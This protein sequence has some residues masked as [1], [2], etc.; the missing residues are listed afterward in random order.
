VQR[1]GLKLVASNRRARFDYEI[2]ETFEAGLVLTG[3]EV[4]SLRLG[5]ASLNESFAR[6]EG[7]EVFLE[8]MHVP[9]YEQGQT[10]GYDPRRTR[11]LL[12]H[13]GEIRRLI[14]KTSER[15]L[16]LVPMRLYFKRGLAKV[17][18]GLGR[19]KAKFEKR[20]AL[21]E[22]EHAREMQ[23]ALGSRRPRSG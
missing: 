16:T 22:K 15:G 23:R 11:K 10:R 2:E 6:I 19:G 20:Q 5:R 13:R 8:N 7:V 14:G 12:L 21:R 17:E 1:D 18:L 4:K 9:P 3:S